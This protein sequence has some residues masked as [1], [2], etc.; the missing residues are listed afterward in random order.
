MA[1][2]TL[3]GQTGSGAREVGFQVAAI[4]GAHYVDHEII[5]NAARRIGAPE[6]VLAKKDEK[7]P[8]LGERIAR[9]M[10]AL[11]ERSAMGSAGDPFTGS[12]G[13]EILLSRT[14]AEAAQAPSS[15]VQELD[16]AHYLELITV[17][18]KDLAE[19]GN[20]VIIG[21]GGQVILREHP[22]A[23]HVRVV[24]PFIVR[25][26]RIIE[27]ERVDREGAEKMVHEGDRN[28]AAYIRKFFKVDINDPALYDII[29]NTAKRPYGV[30][31]RGIAEAARTLG[32]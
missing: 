32:S 28:I 21:R 13:A 18:I 8:S 25:V 3:A 5:V 31:A 29:V 17:V 16:D 26:E 15:K 22:T 19:T 24:A 7:V 12:A 4:L 27:R 1:V 2:V 23:L 10:E 30:L 11:L 9:T 14:Y 6:E 20:V